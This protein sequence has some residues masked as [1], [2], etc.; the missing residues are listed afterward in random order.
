MSSTLKTGKVEKMKKRLT[1]SRSNIVITGTLAGIAEYLNVDPTIVRVLFVFISLM[2][3]GS[4]ILLYIIMMLVIPAADKS[5]DRRSY[6]NDNHY[7]N[8]NKYDNRSK[9]SSR[10]EA[11]RVD[12]D[13]WSD[14]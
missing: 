7:Y 11:E 8:S 10:K 5:N 12:E 14:F 2:G 3:M 13:D 9:S 6:G 1:K 4:P